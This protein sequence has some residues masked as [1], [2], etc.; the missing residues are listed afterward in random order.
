MNGVESGRPYIVGRSMCWNTFRQVKCGWGDVWVAQIF[1]GLL[2][3][4][5]DFIAEG[6]EHKAEC[7]TWEQLKLL[8]QILLINHRQ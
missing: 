2:L 5:T 4:C 8:Q 1:M 3:G 7:L 6:S